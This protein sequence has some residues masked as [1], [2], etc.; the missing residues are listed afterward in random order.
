M[1]WEDISEPS[2]Y[3]NICQPDNFLYLNEKN[4]IYPRMAEILMNYI[5]ANENSFGKLK[6]KL[7]GKWNIFQYVYARRK[8][9]LGSKNLIITLQK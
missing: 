1:F 8:C 4:V 6:R 9:S 5:K 7:T 3:K 2:F